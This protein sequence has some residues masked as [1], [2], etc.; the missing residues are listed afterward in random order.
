M[1]KI[2]K[3]DNLRFTLIKEIRILIREKLIF[4][5]T[6]V[7]IMERQIKQKLINSNMN[8]YTSCLPESAISQT[9]GIV[10]IIEVKNR[11]FYT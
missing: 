1:N 4:D 5:E 10:K 8:T 11:L 7:E 9:S 6:D 2:V 3:E